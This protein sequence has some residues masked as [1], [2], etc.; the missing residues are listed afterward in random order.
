VIECRTPYVAENYVEET[1]GAKLQIGKK[2]S[3]LI[4][5]C[6][7]SATLLVHPVDLIFYLFTV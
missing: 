1:F 7:K 2:T 4:W 3:D 5:L 6:E